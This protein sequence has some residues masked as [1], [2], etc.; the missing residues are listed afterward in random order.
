MPWIPLESRPAELQSQVA[1]TSSAADVAAATYYNQND[2]GLLPDVD[3]AAWLRQA[4]SDATPQGQPSAGPDA[5]PE[6]LPEIG[7]S[8]AYDVRTLRWLRLN[9]RTAAD[10]AYAKQL[11]RQLLFSLWRKHVAQ[12][13]QTYYPKL[14]ND[15][16]DHYRMMCDPSLN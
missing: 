16:K 14:L 11:Y 13:G 9:G 2:L 8:E 5:E 12:T 3:L 7:E 6:E 1:A 15:L 10:K 4:R